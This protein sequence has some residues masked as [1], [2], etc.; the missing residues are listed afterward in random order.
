VPGFGDS[1]GKTGESAWQLFVWQVGAQVVGA[2]LTPFITELTYLVNEADP[3]VVLGAADLASEV[4]RGLR[5]HGDAAA[6]ARKSGI[7]AE[8]FDRLIEM[9]RP[10]LAP[11]DLA[12]LVVRNFMTA[13]NAD[14]EAAFSGVDPQHLRLMT[15]IAADAP[16]PGDLAVAL[17]RKL[18]GEDSA[19][20]DSV[21]FAQGIREG[22]LAD[23]YIP[24]IKGLATEWPSPTDALQA[25]LEGQ[26]THAQALAEYERLGGDPQ[27]YTWLFNTRG[28]APTPSQALELLNR[29]IIP[30]GGTGPSS[31][32]YRQAFLEG[33]WRNKWSDV[34]L[35]LRE[36]LPPPRTVTA[37]LRAGSIDTQLGGEWL[38][39]QGLSDEAVAAYI[40]DATAQKAAAQRDLTQAQLTQL[41]QDQLIGADVYRSSLTALGYDEH[42]SGLLQAMADM[43]WQMSAMSTATGRIHSLYVGWKIDRATAVAALSDLGTPADRASEL[44]GIW[45]IERQAN[46]KDLTGPQIWTLLKYE[47]IDQADALARLEQIGYTPRDAWLF[48]QAESHG[49]LTT[50]APAAGPAGLQS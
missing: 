32:S 25:E 6:E 10:R 47:V 44:V 8:R 50:P 24:M 4:V 23:K 5:S 49:G 40:A 33:P 7:D 46:T 36:Y 45:G 12:Q 38:H 9:A 22:R 19:G 21:S 3:N 11:A 37:M 27:F 29:G 39:K 26:L 35:A 31:V 13:E 28:Q 14:V 42:E 41:Y 1:L 16:A 18:I 15:L 17:R 30:E 34:F 2:L 20:P 48:L 43:R